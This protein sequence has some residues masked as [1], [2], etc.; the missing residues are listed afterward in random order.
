MNCVFGMFCPLAP[1]DL[2]LLLFTLL[3]YYILLLILV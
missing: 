3:I 2:L 1:I